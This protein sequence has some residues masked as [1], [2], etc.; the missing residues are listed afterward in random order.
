MN[1]GGK[2]RN[3]APTWPLNHE[4]HHHPGEQKHVK[5]D[6]DQAGEL[7]QR[8][9]LCLRFLACF[10]LIDFLFDL[11]DF[12]QQCLVFRVRLDLGKL[13]SVFG[14]LGALGLSVDLP[15]LALGLNVFRLVSQPLQTSGLCQQALFSRRDLFGN[16][17]PF[18]LELRNPPVTVLH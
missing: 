2:T 18:H 11:G 16:A 8:C 14:D 9:P 7:Q 3:N 17:H 1:K 6:R 12:L 13:C 15:F 10:N 5:S 4:H